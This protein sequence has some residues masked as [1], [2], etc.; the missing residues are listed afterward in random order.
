MD[1]LN[2]LKAIWLTAKTDSLPDADEMA[3]LVK[4]YR[5]KILAN[6]I[7]LIATALA[8]AAMMAL[9]MWF[10]QP[11]ML[12]TYIGGLFTIIAACI[13]VYTNT[14]SIRRFYDLQDCN[15][16]E[17][18]MFLEKTRQNQAYYYKKT[19]VAGLAFCSAG[20]LLYLFEWV[21]Q[22]MVVCVVAY[23]IAMAFLYVLWFVLRP[24]TFKKHT[25]KLTALI[26]KT[27]ALSKQF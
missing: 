19:Q 7:T 3:Q 9:V 22:D 16:R 5:N 6:K 20:L 1:N 23:V 17:F 24:R 18:L 10:Y 21:R 13:L 11:T 2:D 4:Q 27:T 14:R 12:T 26:E 8:L 25:K 15:N